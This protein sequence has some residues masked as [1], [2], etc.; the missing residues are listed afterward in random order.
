MHCIPPLD[1]TTV[2]TY[3][4]IGTYNPELRG[5]DKDGSPL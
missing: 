5:F 1:E 4:V 2:H 3:Y